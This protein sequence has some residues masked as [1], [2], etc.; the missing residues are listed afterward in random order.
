M[1]E[2]EKQAV[3]EFTSYMIEIATKV[4]RPL[5]VKQIGMIR[6]KF[7]DR[8]QRDVDAL[9][10]LKTRGTIRYEEVS[11]IVFSNDLRAKAIGI[12][13]D[14]EVLPLTLREILICDK[15]E[16]PYDKAC[17]EGLAAKLEEDGKDEE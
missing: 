10:L 6:D 8:L 15:N 4:G 12:Y 7:F 3:N 17:L 1:F 2:V 11:K 16:W 5:S 13:R 9:P 14:G